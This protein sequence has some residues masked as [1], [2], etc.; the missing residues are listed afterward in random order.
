MQVKSPIGKLETLRCV[1]HCRREFAKLKRAN[2]CRKKVPL[3]TQGMGTPI[4]AEEG[5][6]LCLMKKPLRKATPYRLSVIMYQ[7]LAANN[8]QAPTVPIPI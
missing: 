6:I 4:Y 5:V 1:R 8:L 2:K 7:D 3:E